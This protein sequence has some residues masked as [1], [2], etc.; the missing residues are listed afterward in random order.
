[1]KSSW[2]FVYSGEE[3][4]DP[5]LSRGLWREVWQDSLQR[6]SHDKKLSQTAMALPIDVWNDEEFELNRANFFQ[7][8]M[9]ALVAP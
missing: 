3:N 2:G 7:V 9:V 1:M 5:G 6:L 8:L 4:D